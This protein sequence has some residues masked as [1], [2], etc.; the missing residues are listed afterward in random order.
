MKLIETKK[1]YLLYNIYNISLH[2]VEKY[3]NVQLVQI[4]SQLNEYDE[5]KLKK[6]LL[7]IKSIIWH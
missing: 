3:I 5:A 2:L 1:T 6:Y 7:N 4:V